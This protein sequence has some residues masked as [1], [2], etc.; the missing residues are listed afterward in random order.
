[1]E[2]SDKWIPFEH[3]NVLDNMLLYLKQVAA[4]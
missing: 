2:I 3:G 4:H 1:M